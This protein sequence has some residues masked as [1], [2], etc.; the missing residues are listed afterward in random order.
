MTK[1]KLK[2]RVQQLWRDLNDLLNEHYVAETAELSACKG[3]MGNSCSHAVGYTS[4]WGVSEQGIRVFL[5]N[6]E[7]TAYFLRS[8]YTA[9][10][11]L[12]HLQMQYQ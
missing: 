8:G 1:H 12:I 9:P 3:I 10:N 6:N 7:L 4:I 11:L 5:S 2:H